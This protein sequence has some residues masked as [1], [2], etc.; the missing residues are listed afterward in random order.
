MKPSLD[1]L[2]FTSQLSRTLG[3]RGT[4][5]LFISY[6]ATAK[7]LRSVTPAFGRLAAVERGLEVCYTLLHTTADKLGIFRVNFVLVW[8]GSDVKVKKSR[9][10]SQ[11][12]SFPQNWK[13]VVS[14]D[15]TMVDLGSA[16]SFG[17]HTSDSLNI[18]TPF[19]RFVKANEV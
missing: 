5:L 19:S 14:L 9:E 7:V 8:A 6:Y 16:I 10:C 15:F 4:V 1:M 12:L 13:I 17:V 11:F 3:G 18:S 2:I